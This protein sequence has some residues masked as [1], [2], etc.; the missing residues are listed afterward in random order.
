MAHIHYKIDL[1][2][3]VFIVFQNKVLLR[4]HDKYHIWLSVGGHIEIDED[5]N[6]AAIREVKEEVGLNIELFHEKNYELTNLQGYKELIPPQFMNRHR[7]NDCHE[8]VSLVYFA[9]SDT[10]QLILCE[11]EKSSG[12]KWFAKED[13][14]DPKLELNTNIKMY[15]KKAL[16]K[17][18]H[19]E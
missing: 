10:D 11:N 4:K 15:A 14:E 12:C 16:E 19:Q 1:T 5:P 17:L 8:H 3:E 18:S 7:I 9:K 13:L 2:A 6:Q